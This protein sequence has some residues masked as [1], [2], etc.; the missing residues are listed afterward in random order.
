MEELC[1]IFALGLKFGIQT[2]RNHRPFLRAV[3]LE[4]IWLTRILL[5]KV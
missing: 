2:K 1:D 5:I 4:Y 3:D